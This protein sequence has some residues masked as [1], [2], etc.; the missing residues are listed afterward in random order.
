MKNKAMG[1]LS[2]IMTITFLW[3]VIVIG[4]LIV[5]QFYVFSLIDFKYVTDLRMLF[6]EVQRVLI[7]ELILIVVSCIHF[8]FIKLCIKQ[9]N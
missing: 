4:A 6:E 7:Y 1:I 2:I 5:A 9:G 8:I 3:I